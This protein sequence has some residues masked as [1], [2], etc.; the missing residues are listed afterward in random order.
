MT[1]KS[2]SDFETKVHAALADRGFSQSV[3]EATV[4]V[5]RILMS[6]H[7][8][9]G[10]EWLNCDVVD[11]YVKSQEVRYQGNAICRSWFL[12]RKKAVERILQIYHTNTVVGDHHR[13]MSDLSECFQQ[14][15]L[16]VLSNEEWSPKLRRHQYNHAVIF[17]R[18]LQESRNYKT[19]KVVDE[20]AVREHLVECAA[21]MVGY[22]LDNRR[23]ALKKLFA[24]LSEEGTVSESMSKL[25]LFK[26]PIEKKVKYF[27]PQDEIAAVL[28]AIDRNTVRGKRDYAVILL[29]AVTGL[30]RIDIVE[31]IL[32]SLD[33]RNGEI[34][35]AQEKTG[36]ALALPLTADVGEAIHEYICSSRPHSESDKV[37]LST[38]TPFGAMHIGTLN[39]ILKRYCVAAGLKTIWG[40]HSL[41]RGLATSMVTAGVPVTTVAQ[42]LGHS[43]IDSTKQYISLDRRHLKECALDFSGIEIGGAAQ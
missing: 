7:S 25:F 12:N 10:E 22:S 3:I 31:M 20:N 27:M 2:M 16:R 23:R 6:L 9:K 17:F 18:W 24:F 30:R 36:K 4:V 37:F 29:A 34:R 1:T 43:S 15:L 5:A 11:G 41:R 35:I 28:N 42:T 14:V 38:R 40:S 32:D 8:K 26:I 39:K 33:W 21:R 19:L 13:R